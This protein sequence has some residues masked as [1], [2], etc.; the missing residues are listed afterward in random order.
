LSDISAKNQSPWAIFDEGLICFKNSDNH[1][2]LE[3]FQRAHE[4]DRDNPMFTSYYGRL[5][6]V[7]AGDSAR[8][9][10][11]CTW[12]LKKEKEVAHYINLGKIYEVSGNPM[13]AQRVYRLGLDYFPISGE[14]Q[15]ECWGYSRKGQI[16]SF[17]DRAHS[18]N[19]RLGIFLRRVLPVWK[20]RYAVK[21]AGGRLDQEEIRQR[22]SSVFLKIADGK[23][24]REGGAL[25]LKDLLK[26]ADAGLVVEELEKLTGCPPSGV[27]A[28][29]I[30]HTLLLTRNDLFIGI[31]SKFL[32]H[33][34][35]EI[36]VFAAKGLAG[37][38]SFESFKVLV[39]HLDHDGYLCRKAAA[40]AL[41]ESFGRDGIEALKRHI[42]A[43]NGYMYKMT[44]IEALLKNRDGVRALVEIMAFEETGGMFQ[45]IL[46]AVRR[47]VT[48]KP[49][50]LE[51]LKKALQGIVVAGGREAMLVMAEEL[52]KLIARSVQIDKRSSL[53]GRP[54]KLP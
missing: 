29:T 11:L 43:V 16:V 38:G 2:A 1:R 32:T 41:A 37:L 15:Q 54:N 6:A 50:K 49:Q 19:K 42:M 21:L 25:F 35:E 5:L 30:L 46:E 53:T 33:K 23:V 27:Y 45:I 52:L 44:S 40:E 31:L 51:F 13:A 20:D 12:A 7:Y 17:L 4:M 8:G 24:T 14:L 3:Y 22:L 18:L 10:E 39:K 9:L 26:R 47:R 36:A 28:K 48:R 34:D